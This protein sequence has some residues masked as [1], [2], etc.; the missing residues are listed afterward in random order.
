MNYNLQKDT[1]ALI[2]SYIECP[3]EGCDSC[4]A[5]KHEELYT[6][7]QAEELINKWNKEEK[8]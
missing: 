3:S 8:K 7:K 4:K 2:C 5:F 6:L 1:R